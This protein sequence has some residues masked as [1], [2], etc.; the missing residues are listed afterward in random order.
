L[1]MWVGVLMVYKNPR[2]NIDALALV[3]ELQSL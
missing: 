3:Y 2:Y 1:F